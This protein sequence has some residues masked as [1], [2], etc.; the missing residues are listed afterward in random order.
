MGRG[1]AGSTGHRSDRAGSGGQQEPGPGLS[2]GQLS[3][4]EGC[5][6]MA[7]VG[8]TRAL[9]LRCRA[10]MGSLLWVQPGRGIP[11]TS[12]HCLGNAHM[13]R[14]AR[15]LIISARPAP[16]LL[17][18]MRKLTNLPQVTHQDRKSQNLNSVLS[19]P[20]AAPLFQNSA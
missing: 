6:A 20:Q 11:G 18:Q 9:L 4:G 7:G 3:A 19:G 15:L 13:G 2:S 1:P 14:Y 12:A 16:R 10:E 5:T 8:L 17:S